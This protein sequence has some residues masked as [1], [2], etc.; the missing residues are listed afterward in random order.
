MGAVER[1]AQTVAACGADSGT[2][3][4][5]EER[6]TLLEKVIASRRQRD[7]MS[8]LD[9]PKIT[10]RTVLVP[11]KVR[12]C[13]TNFDRQDPAVPGLHGRPDTFLGHNKPLA[14]P[15]RMSWHLRMPI[16]DPRTAS[17]AMLRERRDKTPTEMSCS[18]WQIAYGLESA[19]NP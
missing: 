6:P 2:A 14:L 7:I 3:M 19:N 4:T 1:V 13:A 8:T 12:R 10:Q 9:R 11:Q 15:G 16:A 18:M 17:D 5:E